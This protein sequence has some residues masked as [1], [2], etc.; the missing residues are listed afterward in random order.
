MTGDELLRK[1]AERFNEAFPLFSF[2]GDDD[3][4]VKA[5]NHCLETN[6]PYIPEYDENVDY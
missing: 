3:E 5:I 2:S 4:I 1:Y 6:T